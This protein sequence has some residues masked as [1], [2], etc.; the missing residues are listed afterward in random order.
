MADS[1]ISQ[2]SGAL[3]RFQFAQAQNYS[4][5]NVALQRVSAELAPGVTATYSNQQ[6]VEYIT[7]NLT[8]TAAKV[9][10]EEEEEKKKKKEEEIPDY[11]IINYIFED[12]RD[13]D[14][15]TRVR[16]GSYNSEI[17]GWCRETFVKAKGKTM[18]AW[19]GD[20]TQTGVESVVF[21]RNNSEEVFPENPISISL[22]S[23]WYGEQGSV[24]TVDVSAYKGGDVYSDGLEWTNYG[25]TKKWESMLNKSFYV[26]LYVP[27]NSEIPRCPLEEHMGY[28]FIPPKTAEA[29]FK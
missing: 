22:A 28:V 16:I 5:S 15:R 18:L 2:F 19:A 23:F 17:V 9:V 7:L 25:Y 1:L 26:G 11:Y 14:T 6:G 3:S 8:L 24:V 29:V 4:L 27:P 13:L 21:Y 12:G 20:N 10:K